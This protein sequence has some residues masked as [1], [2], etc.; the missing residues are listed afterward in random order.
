[1]SVCFMYQRYVYVSMCFMGFLYI[2]LFA[3]KTHSPNEV[4][5]EIEVKVEVDLIMY[6]ME[7]NLDLTIKAL[8]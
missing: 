6:I 3:A 8:L 1:M 7:L 5:V 2:P 4:A